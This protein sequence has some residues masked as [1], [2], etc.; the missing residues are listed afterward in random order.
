M[1]YKYSYKYPQ[2][3]LAAL[4]VCNTGLQRCEPGYSWGPGVRDHF[5]IH[6][7]ISGSGVYESDGVRRELR[8]GDLFL[9]RPDMRIF[10]QSS[11][12]DPWEYCW[13]GFYGTDAELLLERIDLKEPVL[14]DVGET[15]CRLVMQIYF[16]RGSRFHESTAMTGLL[17][18][19]LALLMREHPASATHERDDTVRRACDYIENHFAL[20]IGISD[21]ARHVG[22]SRSQLYRL[23][24]SELKLTPMQAL[25]QVRIRHA[26]ALLRRGDL[27]V[28]AVAASVGFENPLY[29]SRRFHEIVGSPPTEYIR[30]K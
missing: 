7:V 18:Q 24:V 30:S 26:C 17:Y 22:V 10:Y 23:F 11:A 28:K 1:R 14:R 21:V 12:D 19:L 4:N 5:L 27:S 8:A 29:F 13:V 3:E 6:Y 15:V 9:S 16:S 20:P 2:R 25:T